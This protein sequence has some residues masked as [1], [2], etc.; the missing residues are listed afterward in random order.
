M[1]DTTA[2]Y[3]FLRIYSNDE[4][5]D[6][7]TGMLAQGWVID[8]CK[9]NLLFF[10]KQVLK[11]A[12][13][14][15]VTTE[16]TKRV[17]V[18]DEQVDEYIDIA[19]RSGWQLLCIGDFESVI[20]MRRRLYFYT[21]EPDAAPLPPDETIDFQYAC[22]ARGSTLRWM[23]I[24]SLLAVAASLSTGLFMAADGLHATLILIDAPLVALAVCSGFLFFNRRA[25][26]RFVT[27]GTPM[28]ADVPHALRR[29]ETRMT[30][31]LAALF[32]GVLLLLFS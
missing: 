29:W 13:L 4:L 3:L 6:Y 19:K 21:K 23:L 18:G 28:H 30:A 24:W 7:L 20:P 15:V 2:R 32:A 25:L 31:A 12:R 26:Y 1:A 10:R 14:M 9:G 17:P 8:H 27:S 22:R 16:C 11:N 5:R